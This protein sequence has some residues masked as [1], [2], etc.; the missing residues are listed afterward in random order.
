[1]FSASIPRILGGFDAVE[2]G[3]QAAKLLVFS[4]AIAKARRS[5]A[6]ARV[7]HWET[8]MEL[9]LHQLD[10]R[11]QDLRRRSPLGERQLLASL[12][13][14][15]QQMPIVVVANGAAGFVLTERAA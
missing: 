9:E 12:A 4:S 13:E 15:G 2:K 6:K 8:L 14:I 11:Y 1:M 7:N 5:A 3:L 10:L